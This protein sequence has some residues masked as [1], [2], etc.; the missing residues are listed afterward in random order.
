MSNA[1]EKVNEQDNVKKLVKVRPRIGPELQ[2]LLHSPKTLF[3]AADLHNGP[4]HLM[5]P[6]AMDR[7]FLQMKEAFENLGL[8]YRI[9][10]AHKACKSPV[11]AR[12]ARKNGVNIDVASRNELTSALSAGFAG[13]QIICTGPKNREFVRL[14]L[15]HGCLMSVDSEDELE[16]IADTLEQHADIKTADILLRI[17]NIK[18][19][20]R[21][22]LASVSRFGLR[23][24]NVP[25][26]LDWLTSVPRINLRGFHYHNDERN[27]DAKA[28][29]ID[30]ALSLMEM[31]Y[32][33]GFTPD[34]LDIG[35]GLRAL[36]IA[37][38]QDWSNF[39][40][41]VAEGLLH[42]T[43]TGTW[44]NFG[45]GM[46]INEKG[47]IAGRERIQGKYAADEEFSDVLASILSHDSFRGRPLAE[48]ITENM[49]TVAIEPGFASL[50]Q[51]GLTI[52]RVVG[53]K[54][55]A[56]G[57]PIILVDGNIYSL[58]QQMSEIFYDPT[59]ISRTPSKETGEFPAIIAGNMCRE[60]D[61]ITKRRIVFDYIPTEGDLIC[62]INTLAYNADFEDTNPHQHAAGKRFV[63]QQQKTGEWAIL[64][65]ELY[66]PYLEE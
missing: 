64:S 18:S 9:F 26:I 19:R 36:R 63:A 54:E 45:L 7:N 59:L 66:S 8:S 23:Q 50:Q 3:A 41:Q 14:A 12:Q 5:V 1:A 56:D 39:I 33:A 57:T 40:D 30:N 55:A 21:V 42:K 6:Q 24:E 13:A 2:A 22:A 11:M 20:D 34:I 52:L 60:E 16:K 58:S 35:G 49:F 31:A 61:I 37:D 38:P 62:F 32:E 15:Q 47:S 25:M 48:I 29:F 46:S 44:R 10:Y 4:V 27:R 17:G 51:C 43:G 53:L 65:E 28:G